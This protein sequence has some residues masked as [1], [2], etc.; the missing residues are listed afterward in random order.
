MQAALQE[1]SARIKDASARAVPLAIRGGGS[2]AFY[3]QPLQGEPLATEGLAGVLS[4]EPSELVVTAGAG[5][6][7]ALLESV[8]AERGQHLPF[9]PPHFAGG[10]TVG[11]M[12][13]AGLSGPA[14]AS[15]GSVRDHVL[16]LG[17]INGR[18]ECLQFGGQVIKNVAGYDVSRLMVGA[19][20]TLGLITQVS[21]KVLGRP[22]AIAS[23][24]FALPQAEALAALHRWGGQGL[25][26]GASCWVDG[27]LHVRLQGA[28]AAVAQ[29]R[30]QLG[31]E[32]VPPDAAQ[33]LWT[34]LRDQRHAWFCARNPDQALWRLSLPP[35]TPALALSET[36]VEWHG[37]QRWVR[38]ATAEAGR[39]RALARAHG[40]HATCF[41]A[42]QADGDCSGGRFDSQDSAA[43]QIAHRL[44]RAFD[45]AGIFN[46][47]RL[48]P[49]L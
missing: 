21:L 8:L 20:G 41:I 18:G 31:G 37:G 22:P 13:A 14:R 4:Y 35:T 3:G 46:P 33:A 6:P 29:A 42:A 24:R 19:L 44:K 36:L 39:L 38:A 10:A 30:D 45:P 16:G 32:P 27:A 40:G 11:G 9:E 7:L 23:L 47:G 49:G 17:L 12:V 28:A 25:P 48:Y 34:Q 2:K 5:T 1:L 43:V 15:A 26:V